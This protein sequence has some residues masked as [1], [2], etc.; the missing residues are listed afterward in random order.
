MEI[1]LCLS[2][3]LQNSGNLFFRS[4][5]L[6]L[7]RGRVLRKLRGILGCKNAGMSKWKLGKRY[8]HFGLI[9]PNHDFN[10]LAVF[11]LYKIKFSCMCRDNRYEDNSNTPR[12]I[13]KGEAGDHHACIFRK[14]GTRHLSEPFYRRSSKSMRP[15]WSP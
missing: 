1:S 6:I 3:S 4:S 8:G 2:R 12:T 13:S 15:I 7:R 14:I 11:T 5:R 10:L 9:W